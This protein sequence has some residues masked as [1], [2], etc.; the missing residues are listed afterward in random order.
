VAWPSIRFERLLRHELQTLHA[1]AAA[2]FGDD[3]ADH[4]FRRSV[5]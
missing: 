2:A 1:I 4:L 3:R 5:S